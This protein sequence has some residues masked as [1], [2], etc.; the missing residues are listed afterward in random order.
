MTKPRLIANS[1]NDNSI[2]GDRL[3]DGSISNDKLGSGI[4]GDKLADGSVSLSKLGIGALTSDLISYQSPISGS[5]QRTVT[6]ALEEQVSIKDFGA[7]GDGVTNDREVLRTAIT[8]IAGSGKILVIDCPLWV[9]IDSGENDNQGNPTWPTA[10]YQPIELFSDTWVKFSQGGKII[11]NITRLPLFYAISRQNIR[12]DEAYFE[13]DGVHNCG[14]DQLAAVR[15]N[16]IRMKVPSWTGPPAFMHIFH[17]RES[18]SKIKLYN[19]SFVS[20]G[21]LPQEFLAGGIFVQNTSDVVIDGALF[22]GVFMAM[23]GTGSNQTLTNWTSLRYSTMPDLDFPGQADWYPPPHLMYLQGGT[24]LNIENVFDAGIFVGSKNWGQCTLKPVGSNNF[25]I[26]NVVSFRD[27]GL[28]DFIGGN[29]TIQ[30]LYWKGNAKL[31]TSGGNG[32]TP[33]RFLSSRIEQKDVIVSDVYLIDTSDDYV[34]A[35]LIALKNPSIPSAYTNW[36]FSNVNISQNQVTSTPYFWPDSALNCTFEINIESRNPI[37]DVNPILWRAA[38][39]S[40]H[41]RGKLRGF[42]TV[43]RVIGGKGS[44]AVF[45]HLDKNITQSWTAGV[46]E[47]SGKTVRRVTVPVG[48]SITIPA[49]IPPGS[50]LLG[51]SSGISSALGTSGG[52]TGYSVGIASNPNKFGTRNSATGG[53]TTNA[54]WA[55]TAIEM[56]PSGS[57]ILIS[58]VGGNFDGVGEISVILD[59]QTVNSFSEITP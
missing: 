11:T 42:P 23:L 45:E 41:F 46:I 22:D 56:Y 26:S 59:M 16:D 12:F 50:V 57:D 39:G 24:G 4:D 32:V 53:G 54:S 20:K 34:G 37:T 51:L 31:A 36:V 40:N 58:A 3:V 29:G 44:T 1:A 19:P 52:V 10:I 49:A 35:P 48:S 47:L 2:D 43:M 15:M 6:Q 13:Y 7:V 55:T 8:Q 18:C 9:P 27:H 25:Q 21:N 5:V 33:I 28:M 30:N 38:T 17:F 14:F